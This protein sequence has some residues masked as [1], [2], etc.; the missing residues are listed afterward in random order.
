MLLNL[1]V[2]NFALIEEADIDLGEGLNILTGETGA[3]KSLLIDAVNAALGG[4]LR[5]DVIRS[6]CESAYTELVFSVPE[7]EKKEKL[8]QMDVSTEYD[9]IVVSRKI[10]PGRSIHKINDE[11]VTSAKVRQVTSLLLDIHGQHEHQSLMRKEKHLE[12][13]DQYGGKELETVRAEVGEAYRE[14]QRTREEL[15]ELSVDPEERM[16]QLDFLEFEIQEIEETDMKPGETEE[17]A[18]R[19][20]TMQNS[21]KLGQACGEVLRLLEEDETS[22]SEQIARASRELSGVLR[23]SE[24]LSSAAGQLAEI[25][26]MVSGLVRDLEAYQE[27]LSF[28]PEEFRETE[29]R[30]DQLQRLESK[31]GGSYEQIMK[32]LEE[33]KEK[34]DKLLELD[35]RR[36]K[37]EAKYEQARIRLKECADRLSG[38]RKKASTGLAEQ[39]SAAIRELNFPYVDFSVAVG[40]LPEPGRGG[41]DE[42]EFL[43]SLNPGEPVRSLS[44]VASG[45]E[46]SRIMLAIK[47]VLA[48]KDEIPTLIFDE[49]DTGIS[50]RTAQKIAEKLDLIGRHRQV[51]CIT[52][53]PQIA[54]MADHHFGIRKASE[55]S[56]TIT[57]IEALNEN[58]SIDELARL[59]GGAEIT[60]AVYQNAVEMK[61]LAGKIKR[62]G[63]RSGE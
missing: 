40:T 61:H 62:D 21:Q 41:Q 43:I 42:V 15:K 26:D 24:G 35:L 7:E 23:F 52:H 13:L 16:R 19:Y 48:D 29:D 50:G 20:K 59:L 12:I 4:R 25:E 57:H 51:I 28:S 3:G 56:H 33:K 54:S 2:K 9:C 53:L 38:L 30:L 14:F 44:R 8:A 37:A 55:E 60:E 45:G 11:T 63:R 18:A 36:E 6:G 31:Y 46:L 58:A 22:V 1:H 34:R 17:V 5:G 39:L 47:S 10:L 32:S 49:I 27:D